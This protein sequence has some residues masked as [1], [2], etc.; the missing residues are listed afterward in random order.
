MTTADFVEAFADRA[1]RD[2]ATSASLRHE[3]DEDGTRI[4]INYGT[5]IA[6]IT[7]DGTR[8]VTAEV[9]S[10]TTSKHVGR[11]SRALGI[12]LHEGR[13]KSSPNTITS[14]EVRDRYGITTYGRMGN[15]NQPH[16]RWITRER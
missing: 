8:A 12:D 16:Y 1:L 7:N 13:K 3:I 4:L 11:A 5:P 14:D 15:Y 9:Y 2:G 10:T 6:F